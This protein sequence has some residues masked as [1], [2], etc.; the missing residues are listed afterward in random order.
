MTIEALFEPTTPIENVVAEEHIAP[1]KVFRNGQV[2]ILRGGKTYTLTG[3]EIN[4]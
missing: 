3:V 1:R 2:Y 4:L